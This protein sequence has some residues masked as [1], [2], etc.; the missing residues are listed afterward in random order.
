MFARY[1]NNHEAIMSI[2]Y[3]PDWVDDYV[4]YNNP[5]QLPDYINNVTGGINPVE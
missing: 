3:I 2:K 4:R 5:K 1:I